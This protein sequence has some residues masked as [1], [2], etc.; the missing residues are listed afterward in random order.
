MADETVSVGVPG[1]AVLP[2][3]IPAGGVD[4]GRLIPSKIVYVGDFDPEAT[5][6][7]LRAE[8][9]ELRAALHALTCGS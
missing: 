4:V 1:E 5:I 9:A 3:S 2:L 6:A 7:E 8:V